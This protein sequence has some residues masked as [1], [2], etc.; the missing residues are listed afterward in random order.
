METQTTIRCW[1]ICYVCP[2]CMIQFSKKKKRGT[3]YCFYLLFSD[4]I[5]VQNVTDKLFKI[6]LIEI[7]PKYSNVIFKKTKMYTVMSDK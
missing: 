7:F 2:K 5:I 4:L 6:L 1:Y 3:L